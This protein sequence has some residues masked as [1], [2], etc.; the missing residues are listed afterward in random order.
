MAYLFDGIF[1]LVFSIRNQIGPKF[2]QF[3]LFGGCEI[4]RIRHSKIISKL[5]I[6]F[7]QE[8]IVILDLFFKSSY[9]YFSSVVSLNLI[10]VISLV[11]TGK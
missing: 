5:I 1:L 7:Y 8:K 11:K 10:L 4:L 9:I 6:I 3:T 2:K